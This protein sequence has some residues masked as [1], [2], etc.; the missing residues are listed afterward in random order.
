MVKRIS[1]LLIISI[2]AG[3]MF[4][5]GTSVQA[6]QVSAIKIT[7]LEKQIYTYME[8]IWDGY[9]KK[10]KNQD[11]AEAYVYIDTAKEYKKP[12]IEICRAY[13]LVQNS[14]SSEK[15]KLTENE[16]DA[17]NIINLKNIGF[18][19]KKDKWYYN[20][21]IVN[22]GK[23]L[24]IPDSMKPKAAQKGSEIIVEMSIK[25]VVNELKVL[26][27]TGTTNLPDKTQLMITV[28]CK[29]TNYMAQDT[30][31]VEKG[32]FISNTFS[33]SSKPAGR[34]GNGKY[35][36][37]IT[38]PTANVLDPSVKSLVGENGKN[39][40]GKLVIFDQVWGNTVDYKKSFNV[41]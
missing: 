3:L 25:P 28:S 35:K 12:I 18:V 31:T 37:E 6:K 21:K 33:D 8:S 16:I 4:I 22:L 19:Q 40:T 36:I 26:N 11:K 17:L 38:T 27:I 32:R 34:L 30:T 29:Q 10:Y 20:K 13:S 24:P 14:L 1:K 23:Q 2:V 41:K 9:N 5:G 15:L 7:P 39:L